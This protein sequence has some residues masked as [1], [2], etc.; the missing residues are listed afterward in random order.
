MGATACKTSELLLAPV[1][2]APWLADVSATCPILRGR[3][4]RRRACQSGGS[5]F[6]RDPGVVN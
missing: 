4:G 1:L 5:S 6:T 3:P 2:P